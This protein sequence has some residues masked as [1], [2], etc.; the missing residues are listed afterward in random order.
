M[1]TYPYASAR[2]GL[3]DSIYFAAVF[4]FDL[5]FAKNVLQCAAHHNQLF[6]TLRVAMAKG[7]I[8]VMLS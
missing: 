2:L 4:R 8:V 1:L 3:R 6:T 5:A 7:A